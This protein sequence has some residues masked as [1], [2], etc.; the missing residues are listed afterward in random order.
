MGAVLQM[1]FVLRD[2]QKK[3][4][5]AVHKQMSLG[6]RKILAVAPTGFGK[7]YLAVWWC[8]QSQKQGRQVLFVTNRRL[9]VQQMFDQADKFGVSCGIIMA[10]MSAH[11]PGA[12][13]QIAS[14]QTLRSRYFRNRLGIRTPER[15]PPADLILVDEAHNDLESYEE[16]FSFYPNARIIGLTATPVGN[17]GR[18][19]L[20]TYDCMVEEIQNSELVAQGFLLP[21][22]VY[23]PSEPDLKG[24]N[25]ETVSQNKLGKRIQQ[26]TLLGDVFKEWL[27][28]QDRT[29]ICFCPGVAFARYL[30]QQFCHRFGPDRA[31][32]ICGETDL[33]ERDKIFKCVR[34]GT[35]KV[36]VSVDV[37]KE[38]F[39]MPEASC[40]I[41][42]QPNSQLR[43]FWQKVGRV[44]RAH[45][46][47]MS[48]IWLD[49]AGNYWRFPHPDEEPDWKLEGNETSSERTQTNRETGKERQPIMCPK[50]NFVRSAGKVCPKCGYQCGAP[51]RRIRM[52]NGRL[53]YISAAEKR[54]REKSGAEKRRGKWIS[55]LS[56]GLRTGSSL[57]AC[58]RIYKEHCSSPPQAEWPGVFP[59][60]SV[61]WKRRVSDVLT[62]NDL[63][64]QPSSSGKTQ[65]CA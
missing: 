58:L 16:L 32:L 37:L 62:A 8:A 61:H 12:S 9:L 21:T 13:V 17:K 26:C 44:K 5:T 40:G 27:P 38:G 47:Q 6:Q 28:Y 51:V 50:C 30:V 18:S 22:E 29:T 42:L 54:H 39:D 46:G 1:T 2:N 4:V 35:G 57:H 65:R 52:G 45:P 31:F 11:D 63:S 36:L 20:S 10:G 55:A 49:F 24:I 15:M 64:A 60:G 53:K 34:E 25:L 43:T 3:T 48:A 14:L 59:E 23:A 33:A 7:R 41:D 19:L 56:E